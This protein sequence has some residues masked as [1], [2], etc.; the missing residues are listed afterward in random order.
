MTP[1]PKGRSTRRARAAARSRAAIAI[2]VLVLATVLPLGFQAGAAIG[3][4]L[5]FWTGLPKPDAAL[6]GSAII[7]LLGLAA[8][9]LVYVVGGGQRRV[10]LRAL[11]ELRQARAITDEEVARRASATSEKRILAIAEL[12]PDMVWSRPI[13]GPVDFVNRGWFEFTGNS[14]QDGSDVDWKA[15]VHP[16][17]M[18]AVA[19]TQA[20]VASGEAAGDLEF[21]LRH[22]SG[23]YRT[24]LARNAAGMEDKQG[25]VTRLI[26]TVIDIQDLVDT[27]EAAAAA[28]AVAEA[29]KAH[30]R[31]ILDSI[32]DAMVV[33]DESGAIESFSAAA[34]AMFGWSA[35]DVVGCNVNILMPEPYRSSHGDYMTRHIETGETHLMA[36]RV[37]VGQRRD[38][39][40]FPFEMSLGG[41]T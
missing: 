28:L 26:G 36:G 10:L 6:V 16:D 31:L 41:H 11:D 38:G 33:T 30:L 8:A 27:R 20:R 24:V 21:R 34:E 3:H 29:H 18:A 12:A 1:Q 32:P 9:A 37:L 35:N 7:A 40:T 22:R 39:S 2:V 4:E 19:A 13:D 5:A 25:R 17:D 15:L 14:P 23:V